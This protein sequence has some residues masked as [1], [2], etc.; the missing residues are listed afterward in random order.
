MAITKS[1]SNGNTTITLTYT[2]LTG[3]IE[4][5]LTDAAHYLF[6]HGFGDHGTEETPRTFEDLTVA[7]IG[8]IVDAYVKKVIVDAAKTFSSND[9]Q[10]TAR[11]AAEEQDLYI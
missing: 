11:I 8:A 5:T 9:A 1:V 6:D 3:K 10:N 7:E 4:A 2:A